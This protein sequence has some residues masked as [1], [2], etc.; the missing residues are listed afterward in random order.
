MLIHINT[1]LE[2]YLQIN[3]FSG[4]QKSKDT[5][6]DEPYFRDYLKLNLLSRLSFIRYYLCREFPGCSVEEK[7][8]K[9]VIEM[10]CITPNEAAF[11]LENFFNENIVMIL[12]AIFYCIAEF[13]LLNSKFSA[14]ENYLEQQL[15]AREGRYY[16][17]ANWLEGSREFLNELHYLAHLKFYLANSWCEIRMNPG[18]VSALLN[19]IQAAC[20][21]AISPATVLLYWYYFLYNEQHAEIKERYTEIFCGASQQVKL[22]LTHLPIINLLLLPEINLKYLLHSNETIFTDPLWQT[23]YF[24]IIYADQLLANA[25]RAPYDSLLTAFNAKIIRVFPTLRPNNYFYSFSR[26]RRRS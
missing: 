17:K 2:F 9:E 7:L 3:Q 4:L 16:S 25:L 8:I 21:G 12:Q 24:P 11:L 15:A 20:D 13:R 5:G 14:E 1:N 23:S 26:S 6:L 10:F 19:S 18:G 22:F